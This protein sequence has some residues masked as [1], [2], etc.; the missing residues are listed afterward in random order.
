MQW[1]SLITRGD[2]NYHVMAAEAFHHGRLVEELDA[3]AQAG[4]LVDGFHGHAGLGLPLDDVLGD[5]LVDHPEGALAQLPQQR[6]L[7]PRNLP[8]VGDVDCGAK[9]NVSESSKYLLKDIPALPWVEIETKR[10]ER[11]IKTRPTPPCAAW[12]T[13]QEIKQRIKRSPSL[14]LRYSGLEDA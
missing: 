7:V 1:R 8:L 14:A 10:L 12:M 3:L 11:S 6:D 2:A 9:G 4:R 5:A 13:T